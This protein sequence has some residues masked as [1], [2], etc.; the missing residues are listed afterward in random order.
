MSTSGTKREYMTLIGP[1]WLGDIDHVTISKSDPL[2]LDA[3]FRRLPEINRSG[4]EHV[5]RNVLDTAVARVD[6]ASL[7]VWAALAAM[8]DIGTLVASLRRLSGPSLLLPAHVTATLVQLGRITDMPPRETVLHYC[9]WNPEGARRRVFTGDPEEHALV[10]T[11]ALCLRSF[12]N[13]ARLLLDLGR[14]HPTSPSYVRTCRWAARELA[15]AARAVQ[16]REGRLDPHHFATKLRAYFE[17][18]RINGRSYSGAA[19]AQAPLYLVDELVYGRG[20]GDAKLWSLRDELAEYGLPRWREAY[21]AARQGP[22]VI[23]SIEAIS[24]STARH[25]LRARGAVDAVRE[26]LRQLVSFRG[27]HRPL[28]AAAYKHTAFGFDSGSAGADLQLID[29]LLR[30]TR[31]KYREVVDLQVTDTAGTICARNL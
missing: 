13:T 30:A 20:A 16:G 12:E 18:V 25:S 2:C 24:R 31:K 26:L 14:D 21:K 19:A 10:S 11:T 29:S 1:L 4:D 7:P 15:I 6:P 27:R 23:E 9:S 22:S 5:L 8:R 3:I 17:P 28:V